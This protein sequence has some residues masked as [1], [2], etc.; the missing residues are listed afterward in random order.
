MP[1]VTRSQTAS[2]KQDAVPLNAKGF[3]SVGGLTI[4]P[5]T[6]RRSRRGVVKKRKLVT[7]SKPSVGEL[8][9]V[10]ILDEPTDLGGVCV[11]MIKYDLD[12]YIISSEFDKEFVKGKRKYKINDVCLAKVIKADPEKNYY[13]LS[14][15]RL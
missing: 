6:D 5:A 12:G 15:R 2:L 4:P 3:P 1:V 7:L 14:F 9:C 8:V 10:M 11:K 13:D